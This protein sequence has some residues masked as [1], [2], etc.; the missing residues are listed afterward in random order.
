MEDKHIADD[1]QLDAL[2]RGYLS[3]ELDGQLGRSAARFRQHLR[4]EGSGA[5][6]LPPRR[7]WGGWVVGVVGGAMAASIAALW[8]GPALWPT[9]HPEQP[10]A[11]HT[12]T[13][14]ADY[15]FDLADVTLCTQTR[16]GGTVLLGDKT[17]VRRIY[18]NELRQTRWV[19]PKR[20]VS[21]E[22]I[23]PRQDVMLIEMDTY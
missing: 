8:A 1:G 10:I 4:G 23:E 2:V 16:D 9:S 20:D 12:A 11:G 14:A 17:P 18:R 19:D 22:K 5:S 21:F 7:G 13:A 15:Q 3:R 6:P